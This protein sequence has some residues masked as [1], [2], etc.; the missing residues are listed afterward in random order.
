[1]A[2]TVVALVS[3]NEEE[4]FALAEYFRITG[5][6]L[7]RA[8]AEIVKRFTVN[9]VVVG[10]RPAKTVMI[11]KYPSRAAV[12]SVFASPEYEAVKKIRDV[13]FTEYHV[14]I[15]SDEESQAQ[16]VPAIDTV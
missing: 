13:A 11:V 12:E 5:P 2:V 8:G 14:S 1:M 10:H 15:A 3:I 16:D 9:E 6:L 7:E 4:P